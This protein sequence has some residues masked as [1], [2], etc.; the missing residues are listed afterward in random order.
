MRILHV[1]KDYY[2]VLGGIENHLRLVA[3][4]QARRGLDVA[5]LVTNTGRGASVVQSN[6]VRVVRASRLAHVASTP[7]SLDFLRH[8]RREPADIVHLHFPYPPGELGAWLL[9]RRVPTVITYHSD[10]VRQR[11]ILWLYAP[12]LRRI[13]S[14]AEGIIAGSPQYVASSPYLRPVRD[15]CT[16]IPFGIDVAPF[17]QPDQEASAIR[18]RFQP[19]ASAF[20]AHPDEVSAPAGGASAAPSRGSFEAVHGSLDRARP[21][22]LFVGRLRY[23]KGLEYLIEAMRELDATLVVVGSGPMAAAWQGLVRNWSLTDRVFFAGEV[24]DAELPAYYQAADVFVLPASQ[25]S[26]AFGLVQLEAM[27]AGTPVVSTEL[28]TGTSFVNRDGETG[29][30]VPPRDSQALVRALRRLLAQPELRRQM[31]E[32]GRQRVLGR[33]TVDRMVDDIIDVYESILN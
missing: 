25:R 9:R 30:V 14:H 19:T 8:L 13:L 20:H 17:A 22:V 18:S 10:V 11:Y 33:F 12:F 24:P 26:E 16:I 27:A 4:E 7:L 29:L 5:V 28:G 1:Y 15:K 23:Y 31:G 21:L 2:P 6:G 3:E 32:R